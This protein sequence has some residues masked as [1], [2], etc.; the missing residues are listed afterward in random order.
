MN[1]SIITS[2]D[3]RPNRPPM[4]E[5][6]AES[7]VRDLALN[8]K[9]DAIGAQGKQIA[10]Q[11]LEAMPARDREA[12]IRF[13]LK[14]QTAQEIE[15]AMDMTDTQFRLIKSGARKRFAELLQP[16]T[17]GLGF[18]P[19]GNPAISGLAISNRQRDPVPAR[20]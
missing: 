17:A 1:N 6:G 10:L 3:S 9:P 20:A 12:L 2:Q 4:V 19:G 7:A 14:Q 16:R 5:P 11:T 8:P 15:A 13:Y 18:D